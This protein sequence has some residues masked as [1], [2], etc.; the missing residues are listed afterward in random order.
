MRKEERFHKNNQT[1]YL[2]KWEKQ[3]QSKPKASKCS[4][5]LG[6]DTETRQKI[7]KKKLRI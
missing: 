2:N 7:E 5:M 4:R 3:K 6:K 1:F